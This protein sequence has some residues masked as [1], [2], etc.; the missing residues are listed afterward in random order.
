MK[1]ESAKSLLSGNLM[2]HSQLFLLF[3]TFY[4]AKHFLS[5]FDSFVSWILQ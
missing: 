3:L 2:D 5:C 4:Y 1:N